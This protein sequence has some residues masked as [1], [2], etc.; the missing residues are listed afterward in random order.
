MNGKIYLAL[1]HSIW[2][3]QKKLHYIFKEK[4]NYREF[5]ENI[6]H[7]HLSKYK[8]RANIIENILEQRKKVNKGF[9]EK[10]LEKRGVTIITFHDSKYPQGLKEIANPPYLFYLR[11]SLKI[12]PSIAVVWSRKISSYWENA[13]EKIVAPLSQYFSIVSGGAAGCDTK[14]H[15]VTL[16]NTWTTI[17]VI[18]TGIDVDYPVHNKKLYDDIAISGWA[19]ISI[20]RVWEVWN[21]YNFPVRNE[22]VTW[23]SHGVLV[24]EAQEKSGSL[25]TA[26]LA[27]DS[28]RDL[29]AVPGDIYKQ[30]SVGCNNL[31]K[32]WE[33][34][35]V[36]S[37]IDILEEYNFSSEIVPE[38]K[39]ISFSNKIE[40]EIYNIISI[41]S[42]NI[43]EI[44][45]K[46]G[47]NIWEILKLISMLEI[48][49][50]LKRTVGW[51]YEI[52]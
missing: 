6:S 18:G 28:G 17:S 34:K 10:A 46:M 45:I 33:A 44:A 40:Q 8:I 24:V 7:D 11:W 35:L 48:K 27:L 36:S 51:K 31:I 22:I 47:K 9:I 14:A 3:S 39:K 26:K 32:A 37:A 23:L 16:E 2:V 42:L 49:W 20:F 38:K 19:V 5:F 43:N 29:F 1:L 25:I 21:P 4:Q 50:I 15:R 41:E 12:A 13:I 30:N 52:S